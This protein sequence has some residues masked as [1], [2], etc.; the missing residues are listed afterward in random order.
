M[1]TATRVAS[2]SALLALVLAAVWFFWPSGLG[3]GTTYVAT[4]GNSMEPR[5]QTGDM[6]ILRP[7]ESYSVGDVVAYYSP[8]LETIVMH[9][10]VAETNGRFVLQGDNNDWLDEDRPAT[11]EILGKLFVR[12]PEGGTALHSVRSPGALALL[13]GAALSVLGT[14]RRPRGRRAVRA[15]RRRMP[16]FSTSA[17]AR[18]ASMPTRARARQVALG[19]GAVTLLAAAGCGVLLAMPPTQTDT[20]SLQVTQ[21]GDFSYTGA[22]APGTTYPSGV[23]ATGDTV[24]TRLVRDLAVSLTSTVTGPGLAGI[25][26]SMRLEVVVSAADGWSAVL[27]SGPVAALQDG[28]VTA[29]V[30][31][32][33]DAATELLSRHYEETGTA[34]GSATLTVTPV[35]ET[36]GTVQGHSFTAG[37]PPG[38]AFTLDSMSLRPAGTEV[39]G[40]TSSLQTPVQV[41]EVGPRSLTVLDVSVPILVVRK[42]L[43][44]VLLVALAA[45]GIGSWV[46]RTGR[47]D[48]A[49]QFL[50]RHADRILPVAAFT[51]GPTVIDVSDAESL[52]RVAE[53]FDTLVLHHAGPDEDVFAVRDIDATYRFVVPGSPDRQRGRPPVP[54]AAPVPE[55]P[56]LTDR[57]PR[58]APE[59]LDMTLPI[60]IVLSSHATADGPWGRVA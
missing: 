1:D 14:A 33:T 55:P 4:H 19:A 8:S 45:L 41:D 17:R 34:G 3:G 13:A 47:G 36:T 60:P 35:A 28:T 23:V 42:V 38:L 37:S 58:V 30:P 57:L 21:Q 11:D 16:A 27:N 40:L 54:A 48:V 26:G 32:D 12:L 43:G 59:Q 44:G 56:D 49:E 7:A 46:G 20:R 39:K 9:R 2:I 22:T 10:I 5:F 6:A 50:V 52:H 24:W 25:T 15:L 29:S 53:R 51:P 31:I 18:A